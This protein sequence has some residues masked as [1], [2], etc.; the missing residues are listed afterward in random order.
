[1]GTSANDMRQENPTIEPSHLHNLWISKAFQ[2]YS[3]P[4]SS[5]IH[6]PHHITIQVFASFPANPF[7]QNFQTQST[8]TSEPNKAQPRDHRDF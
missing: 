8:S 3:P 6:R 4:S 2:T 1:M 7:A 5:A